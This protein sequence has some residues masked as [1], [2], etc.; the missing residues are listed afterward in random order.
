MR[1][2]FEIN[3]D[4]ILLTNYISNHR[5]ITKILYQNLHDKVDDF[6]E[7]LNEKQNQDRER[8]IPYISPR[9]QVKNKS[10]R[11]KLDPRFK[12]IPLSQNMKTQIRSG[13]QTYHKSKLKRSPKYTAGEP[14]DA[15]TSTD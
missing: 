2:P 12:T 4:K 3:H 10:A 5:D 14:P 6:R 8:P 11:N 13:H 15:S 7:R 9:V 1:D